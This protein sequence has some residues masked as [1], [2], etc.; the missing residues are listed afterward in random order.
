MIIAA[1]V[2]SPIFFSSCCTLKR[3]NY[4]AFVQPHISSIGEESYEETNKQLWGGAGSIEAELKLLC[5][6]GEN[7]NECPDRFQQTAASGF[8]LKP[9]IGFSRQ[10]G[11]YL[12]DNGLEGKIVTS[13]I[14]FSV[15]GAYLAT[16][17][18]YAEAGL[19]PGVLLSSRDKYLDANDDYSHNTNKFHLG[20]PVGAGYRFKNGFG[21][22][23]RVIP[24]LTSVHPTDDADDKPNKS[25]VAGVNVSYAFPSKKKK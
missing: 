7:C 12:E 5:P 20:L 23:V 22:G 6:A 15:L 18:F 2:I 4:V 11:F 13:Y 25:F 14:N 21:F 16:S 10:G 8:V 9:G 1:L 17:G 3:L 24:G 19:Q